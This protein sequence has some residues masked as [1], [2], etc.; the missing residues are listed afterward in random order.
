[1]LPAVLLHMRWQELLAVGGNQKDPPC[2]SNQPLRRILEPR[3]Q[4]WANVR[5]LH[6]LIARELKLDG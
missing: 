2:L 1:M 4:R 3:S 6:M 5:V